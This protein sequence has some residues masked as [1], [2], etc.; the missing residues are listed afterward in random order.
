[1]PAEAPVEEEG[2]AEPSTAEVLEGEDVASESPVDA[3]VEEPGAAAEDVADAPEA[4]E[5]GAAEA[6]EPAEAET[7][8]AD[9][10]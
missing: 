9:K 5:E 2:S 1:V 4:S 8:E 6:D 7:A 3:A 10:G